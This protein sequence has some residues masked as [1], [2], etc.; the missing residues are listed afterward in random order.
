MHRLARAKGIGIVKRLLN[1]GEYVAVLENAISRLLYLVNRDIQHDAPQII[2]PY[3][4]PEQTKRRINHPE[5]SIAQSRFLAGLDGI[6]VGG[7]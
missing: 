3:G 1:H 5:E 7:P 6:N 4:K 2:R